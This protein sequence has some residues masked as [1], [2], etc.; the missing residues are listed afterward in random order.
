MTN[1]AIRVPSLCGGRASLVFAPLAEFV[2]FSPARSQCNLSPVRDATFP[3]SSVSV[4]SP[5]NS[6]FP[7]GFTF[8]PLH[9]S[10][11]SRSFP[12]D[13]GKRLRRL[14]VGIHLCSAE[15]I[16][17]RPPLKSHKIFPRSPTNSRPSSSS[18]SPCSGRP[19]SNSSGR[20]RLQ[21]AVIPIE[22][23]GGHIAAR[24][25][26]VPANRRQRISLVIPIARAGFHAFRRL[27]FQTRE[28]SCRNCTSP[29]RRARRSQNLP[30]RATQTAD[31]PG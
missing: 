26:A 22:F 28:K 20:A 15:L 29:C 31:T 11:H 9:A 25:K 5:E 14:L 13:R 30:S 10:S 18:S 12:G 23:Y 6:K 17:D 21:S 1:A 16:W 8:P 4:T 27:E 7:P 3:K 19:S 24:R 2:T